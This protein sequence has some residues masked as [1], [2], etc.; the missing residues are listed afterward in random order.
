MK[1]INFPKIFAL[2][3]I[4]LIFGSCIIPIFQ[5]LMQLIEEI[6][7]I[8]KFIYFYQLLINIQLYLFEQIIPYIIFFWLII[9]FIINPCL[10]NLGFSKAFKR[11]FYSHILKRKY[12]FFK[13]DFVKFKNCKQKK[14]EKKSIEK[15]FYFKYCTRN[16]II[17]YIFYQCVIVI[18]K[19][20]YF[21]SYYFK[22]F[23]NILK[24][25]SSSFL[26]FSFTLFLNVINFWRGYK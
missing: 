11:F 25:F 2:S 10:I 7:F 9:Q 5:I 21:V 4:T 23:T 3:F 15:N 8:I 17:R 24:L 26:L 12:N 1:Y 6:I 16:S 18:N 19:I 13:F 14:I 20:S 22:K